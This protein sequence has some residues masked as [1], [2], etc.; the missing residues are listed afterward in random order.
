MRNERK[1][2]VCLVMLIVCLFLSPLGLK[3]QKVQFKGDNVTLK[4]VFA[5]I[6]KQTQ[7]SVDYD[8]DVVNVNQTVSVKNASGSLSHAL[9]T[10]LANTGYSYRINGQHIV[11]NKRD[12]NQ[13]QIQRNTGARK[14][15]SGTIKDENGEPVIGATVFE[16]GT[17][18]GTVTDLDGNFTISVSPNS[19]LLISYIG[20]ENM[21]VTANNGM[22]LSLKRDLKELDEVVV[23]GYGATTKRAMISSGSQVKAAELETLPI[24]NITQGLAGRS[25]GLIVQGSGGGINKTST[26]SIRGGDTPLVVID[27]VIRDYSDFVAIDPNDIESMSILKDASA[28][29]VYGSRAGNGIL[30]VVTKKGQ[31]GKPQFTYNFNQS[32][33]QPVIFPKTLSS[34][35]ITSYVNEALANDGK[36]LAYS[37]EVLQKYKDGSDLKN[38]PNFNWKKA[39]LRDWA[40]QSKHNISMTGGNDV[41]QYYVSLGHI[42][43]QSLYKTD[44][45][46]MKQT[47]FKLS[48]T[49]N[50]KDIGLKIS[51]D[52][53]GYLQHTRSPYTSTSSS[54]YGVFSHVINKLPMSNGLNKYEQILNGVTDNPIAETSSEAGYI[55]Q[56]NAEMTGTGNI[57]WSLPWVKG[58]SL[59]A[60]G[61]YRFYQI[62]DKS[63]RN[64]P[65]S[66]EWDST[67]PMSSGE[68][69]LNQTMETG[70]TWTLQ[71][72][73]EYQRAF[74]KHSVSALGGYEMTYAYGHSMGIH[75]DS[76]KFNIDQIGAGPAS[77]QTNSGSEWESGREGFIG[78]LKYNY[79]NR[80]F[81]EGSMRYDGSDNFRKGNRWGT[82][83][84]GAL[85]W[86]L[87]DEAFM[88]SLREK[89]I[90]NML[91][92]RASYGEIGLDS[93]NKPY[94]IS[95]FAYLPSYTLSGTGYVVNG[96]YVQTFT[97]GALP[98]T[99]ITWFTTKQFDAGFDFTSLNDRLYGMFDYFYYKT[100]GFLHAPNAIDVGYT[101][102]LGTS[103][104][105][106]KTNG[107]FRREG[108]EVQLGWRDHIRDFKYDVSF[109]LTKYNQLWANNPDEALS[110]QMNP[111]QRT[112][113]QTGYY[114]VMYHSLGY[115]K[116]EEDVRT[117]AKPLNSTNLQPGDIKYQDVNGD[118]VIT[119]A[120]KIRCGHSSFPT[121][122]YGISIN[123]SYKGFSASALFQGATGFDMY[124]GDSFSMQSA[125]A[126]T[127]PRYTFQKDYWTPSNTDAKFPRL[128]SSNSV[129]GN[130]NTLTSDFWLINGA[131]LRLKDFRISY[132]L[133]YKLLKKVS[134]LSKCSIGLSGQNIFTISD[135]TDY[136]LDPEN[137]STNGYYYPNERV[138]AINLTVGF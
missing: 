134:W 23:V 34:Y 46:W 21:E 10:V 54:Y 111:Y 99:E 94:S 76:Y 67:E 95:R 50:L 56:K 101:D 114:G 49:V 93:W 6:E 19:K 122:N 40:P 115:F 15:V 89:N 117:S 106:T 78:Q 138:Y 14:K 62:D 68:P 65:M 135:A 60:T 39:V 90:I 124:L 61:N 58:L 110:S 13:G 51:A 88:A 109:N 96:N 127:T 77:T 4:Y 17:K 37:D 20:Y 3:A 113:Q 16:K 29:A 70:R 98:A 85:G 130:N 44:S 53:D 87:G 1:H 9:S 80:Y 69:L 107:E 81:V 82:F 103:L 136:G 71:Y 137:G 22:N 118:G 36:A 2:Q 24:T 86:S 38:Y 64:D 8:A 27:G 66:Y 30:Q 59:R 72:F 52:L 132:D 47:N 73:A 79:D 102:P 125:Q 123:L 84:S 112:T 131:Y 48:E 133:K 41:H 105:K 5:E 32:Y 31:S 119:D 74:G 83:Y 35:E 26:I 43:Q 129:N 11:I 63:W 120:D 75:R 25:P 104:P 121:A 116:D 100:T 33:S 97:E 7:H 91:K 18:N 92:L 12:N 128:V 57:I 45:H 55:A 42:D 108:F 28:T 126:P